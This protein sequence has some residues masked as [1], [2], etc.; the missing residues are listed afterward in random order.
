MSGKGD[1]GQTCAT[2]VRAAF[3]PGEVLTFSELVERVKRQ[4]GWQDATI[5]QH[6][7]SLVVNLPPARF[8]WPNASPFLFLREDGR[9]EVHDP[10]RHPSPKP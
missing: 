9:Y 3:R 7:M 4:G 5:W 1:G 8:Q 10:G 6:L 2:A